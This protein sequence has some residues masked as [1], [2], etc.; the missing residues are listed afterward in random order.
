MFEQ[1]NHVND[2]TLFFLFFWENKGNI[3]LILFLAI[4]QKVLFQLLTFFS[5]LRCL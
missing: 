3:I 4:S 5:H 1:S 2:L